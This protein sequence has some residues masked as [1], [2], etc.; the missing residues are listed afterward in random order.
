M[1][2]AH[3][4]A[5][6]LCCV[7]C[8]YEAD[9]DLNAMCSITGKRQPNP[10][11]GLLLG[12]M[13]CAMKRCRRSLNP[14]LVSRRNGQHGF[15]LGYALAALAVL[16]FIV[17]MISYADGVTA[18]NKTTQVG[19]VIAGQGALI[20]QRL[21]D[22]AGTYDGGASLGALSWPA[23]ATV[24][25]LSCPNAPVGFSALWSGGDNYFLPPIPQGFSEWQLSFSSGSSMSIS[26]TAASSSEVI[27]GLNNALKKFSNVEA[28]CAISGSTVTFTLL[29][30]SA[31]TPAANPSVCS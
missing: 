4:F 27:A 2:A 26:T 1:H 6:C 31:T 21:F 19:F 25:L 10:Y 30:W 8:G 15:A 18:N 28:G 17:A 11:R 3:S 14:G 16:A 29:L 12:V 24:R 5:S 23:S 7:V 20:R 13:S 22:C 9:V